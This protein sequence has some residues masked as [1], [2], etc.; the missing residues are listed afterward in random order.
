MIISVDDKTRIVDI[1]MTN[2]EKTDAMLANSLAP[3]YEKYRALKYKTAVFISGESNLFDCTRNIL[4]HNKYLETEKNVK[5]S[6]AK[7]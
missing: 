5:T 4:L 7:K 3:L 2:A 1:W 6:R